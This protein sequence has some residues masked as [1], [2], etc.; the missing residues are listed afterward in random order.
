MRRLA[1][2]M[3]YACPC[4]ARCLAGGLEAKT[5]ANADYSF[6]S[7]SSAFA[8]LRPSDRW[9]DERLGGSHGIS[10][11]LVPEQHSDRLQAGELCFARLIGLLLGI[12]ASARPTERQAPLALA[13]P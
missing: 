11:R 4:A 3:S 13:M 7:L 9:L 10:A 12:W 2:C 6:S 1:V 8:P 5:T